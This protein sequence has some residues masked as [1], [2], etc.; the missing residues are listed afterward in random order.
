MQFEKFEQLKEID[1]SNLKQLCKPKVTE[2]SQG[3][4][5]AYKNVL[6]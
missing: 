6:A 2:N 4:L 5:E 1:D 3:G